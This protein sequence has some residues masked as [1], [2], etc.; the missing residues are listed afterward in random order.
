MY[1]GKLCDGKRKAAL[2]NTYVASIKLCATKG[3][4]GKV[5]KG[6]VLRPRE[7]QRGGGIDFRVGH[8]VHGRFRIRHR[9]KT[10]GNFVRAALHNA[11]NVTDIND[12]D[13]RLDAIL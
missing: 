1:K 6:T 7:A 2:L 11:T 3:E 10:V 13:P 5:G 8:K 4:E 12:G 9:A